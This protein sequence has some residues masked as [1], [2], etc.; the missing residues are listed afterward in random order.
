MLNSENYRMKTPTSKA[1]TT[2]DIMVVVTSC[3]MGVV[4]GCIKLNE[5]Q[6]LNDRLREV[7][8]RQIRHHNHF[9]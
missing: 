2:L 6:E 1:V 3:V 4:C 5:T 7:S 9:K 8:Y